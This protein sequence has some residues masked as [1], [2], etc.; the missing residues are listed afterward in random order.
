[1]TVLSRRREK[2]TVL[3]RRAGRV[4]AWLLFAVAI[5]L[6]AWLA[7]TGVRHVL[8]VRNPHFVLQRIDVNVFGQLSQE[9]VEDLLHKCKVEVGRS[10]LFGLD[11][12]KTRRELTGSH[13]LIKRVVLSRVLPDTLRV[14]VYERDPVA[15]LHHRRGRMLDS[16]GTVLPPGTA[17]RMWSLPIVT[18][19]PKAAEAVEGDVLDDGLLRTALTLIRLSASESCARYLD[20]TLIQLDPA[21]QRLKLFLAEKRPFRTGA[22]ILLP[23]NEADLVE[24]LRRV[25]VIARERYEGRQVTG[26]IDATY[27]VNIPVLP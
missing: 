19:V 27:K 1:M 12:R 5:L 15:Q 20:V 6:M 25:E 14:D 2:H 9:A 16:A 11:L 24:A 26:F 8:L 7:L 17:P 21:N 18:G 10:T 22:Q 3:L 13:V 23:G 4:V